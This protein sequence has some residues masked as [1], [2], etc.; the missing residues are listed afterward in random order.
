MEKLERVFV[1]MGQ[2]SDKLSY[3]ALRTGL[4]AQIG[5]LGHVIGQ[6]DDKIAKQKNFFQIAV[7]EC[8]K[9]EALEEQKADTLP[10]LLSDDYANWQ[11]EYNLS[12][13]LIGSYKLDAV[14]TPA[15]VCYAG[16]GCP[17]TICA[18]WTRNSERYRLHRRIV[19]IIV[20]RDYFY[21]TSLNKEFLKFAEEEI[22]ISPNFM[23]ILQVNA[24]ILSN[25]DSVNKFLCHRYTN[26]LNPAQ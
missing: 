9:E 21:N 1:K 12:A 7:N 26:Q 25:S 18:C 13:S 6:W 10:K 16:I 14:L 17:R 8:R 5:Q 3:D 24:P 4:Q 2:V 15:L 11:N 19:E 20:E 22:Y 23:L